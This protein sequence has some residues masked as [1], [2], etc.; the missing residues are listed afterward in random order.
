MQGNVSLKDGEPFVHVHVV[1][2]RKDMTTLGGHLIKGR[3]NPF[4]E[5]VIEETT[6]IGQMVF[7]ENIGLYVL[8]I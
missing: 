7:D 4:I 2:S 6:N 8:K 5:L 1:L 3:V